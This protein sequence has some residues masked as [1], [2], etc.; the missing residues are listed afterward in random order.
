M[1]AGYLAGPQTYIYDPAA[2]TWTQ[3]GTKLRNDQSDEETWI[4][5]PDDSILSYD[6][7]SSI[8]DNVGHAQ[9]DIPASG[10]R[11]DAGTPPLPLSSDARCR[12]GPGLPVA[13]RAG[14]LLR[15]QWQ[16]GLLH[17][18]D[19]HLDRRQSHS[20]GPGNGRRARRDDAQRPYPDQ[21]LSHQSSVL[22]AG[23]DL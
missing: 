23:V 6:V 9:R 11:V 18:L 19:E 7:F 3:T 5:L 4:K 10:T 13:R 15:R 12:V 1:L 14:A 17:A 20:A 2:N 22:A 21:C 8:T 16:H